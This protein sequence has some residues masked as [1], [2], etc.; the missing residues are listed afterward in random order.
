M[1]VFQMNE[2]KQYPSSRKGDKQKIKNYLPV[3]LI[4]EK[5]IFNS[6]FKYLEDNTCN[7]SD[8]Q[9]CDSCGH[10]LLAITRL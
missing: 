5:I 4:F 1:N 9:P 8:F 7:K 10:Q 6:L 3:S 2:K